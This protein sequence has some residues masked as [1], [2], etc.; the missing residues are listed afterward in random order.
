M[1]RDRWE[2]AY[3]WHVQAAFGPVDPARIPDVVDR[4]LAECFPG[5]N[6]PRV[7]ILLATIDGPPVEPNPLLPP[8]EWSLVTIADDRAHGAR[9]FTWFGTRPSRDSD[10]MLLVVA[11]NVLALSYSHKFGDEATIYPITR[12]L[13]LALSGV[14]TEPAPPMLPFDK[15]IG[16]GRILAAAAYLALSRP[17]GTA[18]A[19]RR[20]SRPDSTGRIVRR[21]GPSPAPMPEPGAAGGWVLFI[22]LAAPPTGG[23]RKVP[24]IRFFVQLLARLN[25]PVEAQHSVVTDLRPYSPLLF[26]RAGNAIGPVSFTADWTTDAPDD[27]AARIGRRVRS[28]ESL[29]RAAVGIVAGAVIGVR[30]RLGGRAVAVRPVSPHPTTSFSHVRLPAD[31]DQRD[32]NGSSP[33][34]MGMMSPVPNRLTINSR[35]IAG[36]ADMTFAY[37][38]SQITTGQ[39]RDALEAVEIDLDTRIVSI[40]AWDLFPQ[41]GSSDSDESCH[42]SA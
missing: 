27:L 21:Y 42:K 7:R 13:W 14:D 22:R 30:T 3:C 16:A 10:E 4:W 17:R 41:P 2:N 5:S 8:A 26:G 24:S 39:V 35:E 6:R 19:A 33:Y 37:V 9:M 34:P 23:G 32:P 20:L 28:G 12:R 18:A 38:G 1:G 15:R 29:I 11:D 25:L 31:Q 40:D 36:V